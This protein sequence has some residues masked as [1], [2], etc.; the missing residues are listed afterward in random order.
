M[1]WLSHLET[2]VFALWS[3]A[4]ALSAAWSCLW[5]L[6]GTSAARPHTPSPVTLGQSNRVQQTFA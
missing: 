3:S 2:R 5:A 6:I 1:E 4:D